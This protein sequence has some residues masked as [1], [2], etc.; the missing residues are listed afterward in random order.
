MLPER[1]QKQSIFIDASARRNVVPALWTGKRLTVGSK[2]VNARRAHV[3]RSAAR[4]DARHMLVRV[5][6]FQANRTF[7]LCGSI[8]HGNMGPS[9]PFVHRLCWA[10]SSRALIPVHRGGAGPNRDPTSYCS[11]KQEGT[12][13]RTGKTQQHADR[14]TYCQERLLHRRAAS[15]LH[16][17][18]ATCQLVHLHP[19]TFR[20]R[21]MKSAAP[22]AHSTG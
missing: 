12:R 7:E 3:V 11:K 2:L 10:T 5:V 1:L 21:P 8:R 22:P 6:R 14:R 18:A 15:C 17:A 19:F 9:G 13:T 20:N 4:Q 16:F